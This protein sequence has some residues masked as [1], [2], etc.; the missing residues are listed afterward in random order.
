MVRTVFARI[1]TAN[2]HLEFTVKISMIEIYMEKIRDLL[3]PKKD[4][5]K[6]REEKNKGVYVSDVTET[7]V[8]DE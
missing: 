5:L 4:N 6:V 2:E 8:T 1:D 3:D 7:Y